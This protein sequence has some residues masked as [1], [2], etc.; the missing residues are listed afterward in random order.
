LTEESLIKKCASGNSLAQ[1][2][3]YE[4]FAGKMMGICLRYTKDYEEAQDVMQDAFIKIFGKLADYEK[5]GSLE[6]WVRRIVVN[7][8]LDSYRKNKK[9]QKN[10]DVDSVDY[11]LEDKTFIIEEL[12][13]DDLLAVIKTI[14]AGY[15]MVFNLFAIEGYSHK[16]IAEQLNITESTSKSQYSRARKLLRDLLVKKNIVEEGER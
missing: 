5:K 3:F 2:T 4:K 7:T 15:Q 6:G 12:N 14:P 10:V 16:E 8:A 9:H 11:L 13:A 1:K